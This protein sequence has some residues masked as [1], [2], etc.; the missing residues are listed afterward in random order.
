MTVEKELALK[1]EYYSLRKDVGF[2]L[3]VLL[4]SGFTFIFCAI[5]DFWIGSI[6]A[7]IVQIWIMHQTEKLQDRMKEIRWELDR[8]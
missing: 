6:I 1:G 8:G 5:K 2:N 4:M 7:I 3:I